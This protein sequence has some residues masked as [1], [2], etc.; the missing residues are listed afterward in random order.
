MWYHLNIIRSSR[1]E[2]FC[3]KGVLRIFTKLTGKHLSQSLFLIKFQPKPATLLKKEIL[4]QLF[5]CEF[6]EISKNLFL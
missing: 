1:L 5:S 4:A 3:K 6:C 2:A